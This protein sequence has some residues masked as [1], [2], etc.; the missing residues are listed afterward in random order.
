MRIEISNPK[1]SAEEALEGDFYFNNT[2]LAPP[3]TKVVINEK[4]GQHKSWD[5][6]G[7]EGWY[8]GPAMKYY[9]YY[10]LYINKNRVERI[11]DTVI[12]P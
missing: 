5:S 1:L 7:V 9:R 3:G 8:L 12:F 10:K 6:Y 4:L 11:S 2:P